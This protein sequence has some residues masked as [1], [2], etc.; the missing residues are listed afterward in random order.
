MWNLCETYVKL[1]WNLC[2]TYVKLIWNFHEKATPPALGKL[3]GRFAP[4]RVNKKKLF[5]KTS[6]L[7]VAHT[8]E[9]EK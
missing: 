3:V 8:Y 2:E 9:G 4:S 7:Y 5:I 6:F 1:I